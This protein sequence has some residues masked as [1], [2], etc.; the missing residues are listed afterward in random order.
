MKVIESLLRRG[1][2]CLSV[3]L[4]IAGSAFADGVQHRN[5]DPA[6]GDWNRLPGKH[7]LDV[8][9]VKLLTAARDG[10]LVTLKAMLD[11]GVDINSRDPIGDTALGWAAWHG[12]LEA[13]KLL[14]ERG[15]DINVTSVDGG[16]GRLA[17]GCT[18]LMLAAARGNLAAVKLIF[19]KYDTKNMSKDE[20]DNFKMGGL[21]TAGCGIG[22]AGDGPGQ[23]E[24]C[25]FF[26]DLGMDI[27]ALTSGTNV[28]G[29]IVSLIGAGYGDALDL[30]KLLVERGAN[31]NARDEHGNTPLFGAAWYSLEAAQYLLAHGAEI[32]VRNNN[33]QTI[34][35]ALA[36]AS[37]GKDSRVFPYL[38]SLGAPIDMDAKEFGGQPILVGLIW[39]G[40]NDKARILLEK[41]ADV[42]VKGHVGK[43]PLMIAAEK[44]N[45][46]GVALL[47]EKGADVNIKADNGDTALKLAVISKEAGDKFVAA[48]PRWSEG[49]LPRA[50]WYQKIMDLLRA[51]GAKE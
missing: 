4:M 9:V 24:V 10:D 46:D 48:N 31:V 44:A 22:F 15:A 7:F 19:S 8:K 51:K 1:L 17:R 14:L 50:A 6:T 18:P 16:Y 32:N 30:Q 25:K 26:L 37:G 49:W 20:F 12:Q 42:N 47:L 40:L 23:L 21:Y 2:C 43:T 39:N 45:T 3:L 11:S 28:N 34:L 27:K 38:L 29:A 13:I 41:G 36:S 35:D 5:T 33:N